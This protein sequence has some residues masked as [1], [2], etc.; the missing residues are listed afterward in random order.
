MAK[1]AHADVL[2]NG[3]AYIRTNCTKI[4]AISTY[5]AGD[6]F[7]TV[8]GNLLAEATLTSA[9]FTLGTSGSN[10]TCTFG[11]GVTDASA[12]A[13]GGGATTHF[14]FLDVAGSKVLWVTE[15]TSDQAIVAANPVAFPS[16]VYTAQQPT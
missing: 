13:S 3:P 10:R 5:T 9:N 12:N 7:A 14:A 8:N 16:L 1:W 4:A 11:A 15:E 6:S 2:D